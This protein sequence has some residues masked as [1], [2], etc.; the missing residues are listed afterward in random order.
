MIRPLVSSVISVINKLY[1]GRPFPRFYVLETLACVPYYAHLSILNLYENFG[2]WRQADWLKLHFSESW[3]EL[4][5]LW[6]MEALDG[7][8]FWYDRL[9]A[10][11]LTII[12]YWIL[13]IVY[14]VNPQEIYRFR[15]LLA[16]HAYDDYTKFLDECE[17]ELVIRPAPLF[18]SEDAQE[19][20]FFLLDEFQIDDKTAEPYPPITNLYDVF[21]TVRD[22]EMERVKMMLACQESN[23]KVEEKILHNLA[24]P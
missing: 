13:M 12:Y 22:Q 6:I 23:A 17:K 24:R 18:A 15:E 11:S 4:Q 10:R 21:S 2:L 14:M 5:H 9:L 16:R 20:D 8:K 1:C 7:D 19:R 3:N